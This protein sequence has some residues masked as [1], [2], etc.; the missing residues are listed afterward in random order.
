[1]KSMKS[2]KSIWKNGLIFL[3]ALSVT[4]SACLPAGASE[5]LADR[6]N[7]DAPAEESFA[8]E[9]P[10]YA[11]WLAAVSRSSIPMLR[12]ISNCLR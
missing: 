10:T 12:Q 7:G 11:E 4:G 3:L 1:M 2:M 9:I 5:T 8:G 6:F